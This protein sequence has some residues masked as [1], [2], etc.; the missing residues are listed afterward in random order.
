MA[1]QSEVKKARAR[2][3][4]ATELLDDWL[5]SSNGHLIFPVGP[6]LVEDV[7][8]LLEISERDDDFNAFRNQVFDLAIKEMRKHF[9][10]AEVSRNLL[11]RASKI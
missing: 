8:A 3:K 6:Q 2:I 5:P 4:A 9:I 11:K 1:T 7:K 10:S